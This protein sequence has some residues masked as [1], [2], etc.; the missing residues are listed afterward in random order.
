MFKKFSK[1]MY[2]EMIKTF[3]NILNL[4]IQIDGF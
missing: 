3:W 2:M 4:L 1:D